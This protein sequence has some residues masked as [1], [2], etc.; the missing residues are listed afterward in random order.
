M[1][2][3]P[4]MKLLT[5]STL[6]PN[7]VTPHH[8]IFVENRLR[9]LLATGQ[10]QS[11]VVA[12]VPWFPI[13]A[14]IFGEYGDF[15][16]V[17]MSEIRH[18]ISIDH[19]RYLVV[20]KIGMNWTP[21][22]MAAAALPVIKR[23]IADGYDF[24]IL[25]AHYFYPDGVAAV[26]IAKAL[27]K[28]VTITARGTDLN[29]VPQYEKPR[30]M[31]QAAASEASAMVTVCQALK[32]SL[33]E[34]GVADERIVVLRN[35]VDLEAFSPPENK[36]EL[37]SALGIH[38][39]TILSVGHLI[40]RK[41]HHL[42]IEA[43]QLLPDIKLLIAGQGPESKR[44]QKLADDL[45]VADRVTFLGVLPREELSQYYGAVDMLILASSREG[46]ANVLLESMACGTAVVAT[47][48]WGTPEVVAAPEAGVLVEKRTAESLAEGVKS[49]Y[50]NLPNK[51]LTRQYAERFSWDD[52]SLGL[53]K[54]FQ[55]VMGK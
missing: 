31:I 24:D 1:I 44:L 5:F 37:R 39:K 4:T 32:D 51:Q 53:L 45:G 21:S 43:L 15:A 50:A 25:D 30:A 20:P 12:P 49:L 11:K 27:N 33:M 13:G 3:N 40:E 22:T 14:K 29:L 23:I 52:T 47:S 38:G 48:I 42:V 35:G 6:Y 8:G 19:P 54:L 7:A 17:P 2:F 34:L 16:R 41:G 10:V 9:H 55:R 46:W 28:P 26:K 18:G 36:D